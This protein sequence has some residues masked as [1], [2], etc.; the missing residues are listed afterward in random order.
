MADVSG[1]TGGLKSG[2]VQLLSNTRPRD[3]TT[4]CILLESLPSASLHSYWWLSF[5]VRRYPPCTFRR[6]SLSLSRLLWVQT[7][8]SILHSPDSFFSTPLEGKKVFPT[9][10]YYLTLKW[11]W[12]VSFPSVLLQDSLSFCHDWISQPW[13]SHYSV[14]IK[15]RVVIIT[16][17]NNNNSS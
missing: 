16:H 13:T 7:Q 10:E 14:S 1:I 15:V 6:V 12:C 2:K 17:N 3:N 9:Q 8:R 11:D 4:K 5:W